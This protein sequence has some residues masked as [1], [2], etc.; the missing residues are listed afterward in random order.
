MTDAGAKY[1]WDV[2]IVGG[3]PAG[4]AAAMELRRLGV[5][6][7]VVLEREAQA[8]GVPR[9]CG[10]P[11]FGL[12]EHRR[13]MTGPAYARANV[14]A[15]ERAGVA[16]R[17]RADVAGLEPGGVLSLRTPEG[18]ERLRARRVLLATGA[19]ETPRSARLLPG[20][21]PLGVMNTGALQA[22]VYL[23]NLIP[24]RRPVIVGTELVSFSSLLTCRRA[25]IRPVAMIEE[26]PRPTVRWPLHYG[27]RLFGVPLR[28]GVRLTDIRGRERVRAVRLRGGDGREEEIACDGVL[29]TGRFT[30][31]SAL[32][33]ISHLA[34]DPGTGGPEV[35]Q[36][37]RCSDPAFF[38]AGNLL[39]PV[40]VSGW[41]WREG[42]AAAHALFA[43][44]AG[45]LPPAEAHA[46][47]RAA[48]PLR[49]VMPQ[50]IVPAQA[51]GASG[52]WH[53]QLRVSRPAAG[54]LT[55]TDGE[56]LLYARRL[57]AIPEQ[58]ILVPLEP[59]LDVRPGAALLARIV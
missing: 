1:D 45:G 5:E 44:L 20:S 37:G 43:D 29:L 48:A 19:R 30:P 25:G 41:C 50:R 59:L 57:R 16:F 31:E 6:G 27:A 4:L 35:D 36:F 3:G 12:R 13:L 10:H 15:A 40:E 54:R 21:R 14:A 17:L 49:F 18:P 32:A 24:F 53:L 42:E 34:I 51:G 26:N 38:A 47:I 23:K 22:M 33:R 11:P 58:R 8:G 46:R 2:A 7:V 52:L 55:L 39:R 28:L 56:R 9:H